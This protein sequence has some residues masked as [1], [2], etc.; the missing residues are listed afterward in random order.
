MER[1]ITASNLLIEAQPDG[2]RL[3]LNGVGD[4]TL[5][6]AKRGEPIRYAELFGT[7]RKLP[8]DGQLDL[9]SIER[10]V[11]GW[12]A[13]DESWHLGLVLHPSLAAARGSRWCELAHWLDPARD[14]HRQIAV[15]AGESLAAQIERPF[16]VIQPTPVEPPQPLPALPIP[17]DLWTFHKTS[18]GR[19]E[20]V[21]SGKWARGNLL[22]ALWYLLWMGAFL[23]LSIS[24]VTSGIAFPRPE[25]LVPAGFV[26]ALVLLIMAASLIARTLTRPNRILFDFDAIHWKRGGAVTT[27]IPVSDVSSIYVSH[28]LGK[29]KR[30]GGDG[31]RLPEVNYG[32]LNL[33]LRD[34]GFKRLVMHGATG[35]TLEG[36]SGDGVTPLTPRTWRTHLHAVGLLVSEHLRVPAYDDQRAR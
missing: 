21:R 15:N 7:R 27:S 36:A 6:V 26:C 28:I 14:A 22:R 3:L 33:D 4:R 11:L 31:A 13:K 32:E 23:L 1:I 29:S 5:L 10:V 16:F 18:D 24:S 25:L 34:G 8:M 17:L 35:E 12:S 2:W 19:Y 9:T 30:R 20:L